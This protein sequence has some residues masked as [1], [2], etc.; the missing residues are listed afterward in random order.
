LRH[1]FRKDVLDYISATSDW[2]MEGLG[3]YL[4]LH[5]R[6]GMIAVRDVPEFY[7]AC[8]DIGRLLARPKQ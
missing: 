7:S 3:F 5:S 8:C 4:I 1:Y 2:H 6:D